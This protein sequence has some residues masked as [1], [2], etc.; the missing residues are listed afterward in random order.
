MGEYVDGAA[1]A[2][3]DAGLICDNTHVLTAE[4]REVQTFEDV[5]AGL[6]GFG[7]SLQGIFWRRDIAFWQKRRAWDQK[8]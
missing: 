6:R 4:G 5:D 3:V 8:K 2:G 7:G 1:A